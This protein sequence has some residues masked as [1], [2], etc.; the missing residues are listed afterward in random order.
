M[1][2]KQ[3]WGS[4]PDRGKG[5]VQTAI[6]IAGS[7]VAL[8]AYVYLL[9]GLVLWLK[10]TA[11]RLPTDDSVAALDRNRL[12]AVGMK[13][14]VF[15]LVLVGA[16]LGLAFAA[17]SLVKTGRGLTKTVR[18]RESKR[19][20]D[21]LEN[22]SGKDRKDKAREA[23]AA[24]QVLAAAIARQEEEL[25][26]TKKWERWRN[27]L[28]ALTVAVLTGSLIAEASRLWPD[29]HP[30]PWL[31]LVGAALA[32]LIWI[33]VMPLVFKKW[34]KGH[35]DRRRLTKTGLTVIAAAVACFFLAAP[36]AVGVLVLLLFLHLSHYLK[37]LP[38]V[39][40]PAH[41]IPSVLVVAGGLSLVVAAYLATPPVTLESALVVMEGRRHLIRGGYVGRS[42]DGVYLAVCQRR[43]RE[44]T[45]SGVTHL[46]VVE[47]G[48]IRR[49]VVGGGAGF[50]LDDGKD[51]SLFDVAR[52]LV[53]KGPAHEWI[54]TVSIDARADEL[55][56]GF[57]R[58]L[59]LGKRPRS[60]ENGV[61]SQEIAV[62]EGGTVS[63]V[64]NE[65]ETQEVSPSVAD[66]VSLPIRLRP[67]VRRVH[68]CEGPFKV[69][70][71][72]KF[73][74]DQGLVARSASVTVTSATG[75]ERHDQAWGCH[76]GYIHQE[77]VVVPTGPAPES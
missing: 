49:V 56:C 15:E 40:D 58:A 23:R 33:V 65:L 29:L 50:V 55:T 41:L 36:A 28:Q 73:N 53:I 1:T 24:A 31:S 60:A 59:S 72:V 14:F 42:S 20:E 35:G 17:W 39:S 7:L 25:E 9:G 63:L 67:W 10:L 37:R 8:G 32:G 75:I 66:I 13:A 27:F 48:R 70:L 52:N 5:G 74:G 54:D 57:P 11:A 69:E 4:T 30:W 46:R 61:P 51:L 19:A 44:P 22:A 71:E 77:R 2:P 43:K 38:S 21:R 45:T 18:V 76:H 3:E 64:G 68:Q 34:L 62:P 12:F 16:V 47:P 26:A 6:G